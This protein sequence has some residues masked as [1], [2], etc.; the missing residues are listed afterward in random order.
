[1]KW[2]IRRSAITNFGVT[3]MASMFPERSCFLH[4]HLAV[5]VSKLNTTS[6]KAGEAYLS[7]DLYLCLSGGRVAPLAISYSN[8]AHNRLADFRRSCSPL[9]WLTAPVSVPLVLV[10]QPDNKPHPKP[11]NCLFFQEQALTQFADQPGRCICASEK[12]DGQGRL[13]GSE[14]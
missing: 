7:L 11:H 6:K 12:I 9:P 2:A 13:A 1:M 4:L 10:K 8:L 3:P 14:R 5:P